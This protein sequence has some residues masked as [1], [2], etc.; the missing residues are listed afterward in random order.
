MKKWIQ[1]LNLKQGALRKA[2]HA[3]LGKKIPISLLKKKAKS[4]GKMGKR[5]RLALLFKKFHKK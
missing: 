3:R 1:K 4:K 2:L 5:A